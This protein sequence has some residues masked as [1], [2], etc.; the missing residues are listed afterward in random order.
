MGSINIAI[1]QSLNLNQW[2]NTKSVI[3]WFGGIQ[4]KANTHFIK[5]EIVSFYPSITHD[6]LMRALEF[7]RSF[8]EVTPSMKSA[9]LNSR[10]SFL[11]FKGSP[12]VKKGAPQHFDVTEGSFDGAEA[13][14]YTHL[15]LPTIA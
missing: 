7:A 14:S 1:R 15:T 5:F 2:R 11:F 12:W 6:A 10:K 3:E 13:V 9:I 8:C 4:H